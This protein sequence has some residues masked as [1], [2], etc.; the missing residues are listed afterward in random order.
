MYLNNIGTYKYYVYFTF[1]LNKYGVK[2][3]N[4]FDRYYYCGIISNVNLK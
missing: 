4:L 1:Q 3:T 2:L